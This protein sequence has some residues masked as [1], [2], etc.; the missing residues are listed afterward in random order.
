MTTDPDPHIDVLTPSQCWELL[1]TQV[2][3][4]LGVA[5]MNRPDIFP[6]NFI[7][8][9]GSIVFRTDEGT[10]LAAA[11]LGTAVAFE[12]DHY[13]PAAGVAWS[14]VL[15]GEAVEIDKMMELF[16]ASDLPLFPWQVAPKHRFVRIVSGEVTGRRFHVDPAALAAQA[17]VDAGHKPPRRD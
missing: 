12:V 8:D 7:V 15:K 2:V 16:D 9:H 17:D 13:D 14:V 5:I 11:V 6:V 4:R 1:H 10:K 3:G